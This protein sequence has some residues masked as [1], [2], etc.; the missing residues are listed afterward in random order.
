MAKKRTVSSR[1]SLGAVVSSLLLFANQSAA[2]ADPSAPPST[3][4]NLNLSSTKASISAA[5]VVGT[6]KSVTI[7][8]GGRQ[9]SVTGS[10]LLTPAEM[11]AVHQVVNTGQQSLSIGPYGNAVSGTLQIGTPLANL[12]GMVVPR[13]V[14]VSSALAALNISGDLSNSG[15][16]HF[17]GGPQVTQAVLAANN[18]FNYG[19]ISS[20]IN[21]ALNATGKIV[22]SGSISTSTGDLSLGANSI[23]NNAGGLISAANNLNLL[24]GN[25]TNAGSLIAQTGN[26]NI[27]TS[28]P[29]DILI[30]NSGG[31]MQALLG[32]INVRDAS[33][34]T[35]TNN[36]T[37]NGGNLFSHELNLFSACGAVNTNLQKVTGT[38]NVHAKEAHI[39]AAT[40][41][42]KIGVM[43]L[44]GDPTFYNTQGSVTID[45]PMVFPGQALAIVAK[46]NIVSSAAG[47]LDTSSNSAN[48]GAITLVAG[49]KF[50]VA[51][52]NTSSS[53]TSGQN[54]GIGDSTNTI[55]IT[56]GSA[57]GGY[58][59]LTGG[60]GDGA[61]SNPITINSKS[62]ST[63]GGAQDG[64]NVTLV[65]YGGTGSN[66]GTINLPAPATT[67][68]IVSGGNGTGANGNV[69]IIAGSKKA[70]AIAINIGGINTLGGSG[71]G[72]DV[73]LSTSLPAI[74]GGSSVSILNGV[75]QAG[76]SFT[77]GAIQPTSVTLINDSTNSNNINANTIKITAGNNISWFGSGNLAPA[78]LTDPLIYGPFTI[79]F[80]PSGT[81]AYVTNF[82]SNNFPFGP[83]VPLLSTTVSVIN[84]KTNAITNLTVGN[85]PSGVAFNPAGTIAYVTNY[86]HPGSVAGIGTVSVI[87]ATTN[88]VTPTTITV[89]QGP[90]AVE[91]NATGTTAYVVNYVSNTV[92]VIDVA[93]SK[94]VKTINVGLKPDAIAINPA[95]TKAYVGNSLSGTISVIDLKTNTVTATIT[96]LN[97]PYNLSVTPDGKF[98]YAANSGQPGSGLGVDTISVINTANNKIVATIN[99]PNGTPSG[100]A[101][102]PSGTFVYSTDY[103]L[104][105][106][107]GTQFGVDGAS[108]VNVI[109]TATNSIVHTFDLSGPPYNDSFINSVSFNPSG[110]IAYV[111]N[112]NNSDP[113]PPAVPQST[114]SVINIAPPVLNAQ[115]VTLSAG[116]KGGGSITAF[117][118]TPALTANAAGNV[119]VYNTGKVALVAN[120]TLHNSAAGTF[121][122]ITSPDLAGDG[123]IAINDK[124]TAS[125]K[126]GTIILQSSDATGLGGI[127]QNNSGLLAATTVN[128]SDPLRDI[129]SGVQAILTKAS[130]LQ[131]NTI[132]DV[133]INNTGTSTVSGASSGG[134]FSLTSSGA[135]KINNAIKATTQLTLNPTIASGTVITQQPTASITTP[136][137]KISLLNAA[138]ANLTGTQNS[139]DALIGTGSGKSSI[140]VNTLGNLQLE[141]FGNSQIATVTAGG[142]ITPGAVPVT[143][144][145]LTAT[146]NAVL[147]GAQQI[148]SST[149]SKISLTATGP[150]GISQS[151]GGNI[152][153]Q[154]VSLSASKDLATIEQSST[155]ALDV[156]TPLLSV[157]TG[158]GGTALINNLGT[159]PVTITNSSANSGTISLTSAGSIIAKGTVATGILVLNSAAGSITGNTETQFL[160]ANTV[161]NNDINLTNKGSL[162]LAN[163]GNGSQT[164]AAGGNF[165]LK[166]D[167]TLTTFLTNTAGGSLSFTAT[168][169]LLQSCT[170][171]ANNGNVV[172]NAN[173]QATGSIILQNQTTISA[174]SVD[175]SNLKLGNVI[176]S[177][178]SAN[179]A[180]TNTTTPANITPA[181]SAGG[182]IFYGK[183]SITSL[184]ANNPATPPGNNTLTATARNIIFSTGSAPA[185]AIQLSGQ[186]S[187]TASGY[188]Q[189]QELES[190]AEIIVDTGDWLEGSQ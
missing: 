67:Q 142:A 19:I 31:T 185:S 43:D 3:G 66:A 153:A 119:S 149:T 118:Q 70:A 145:T 154:S 155:T 74:T 57:E 186:D 109:N 100:I 12:S 37:I 88:T 163:P 141:T 20:A 157:N 116:S 29:T 87:D 131:A 133:F 190:D 1:A 89:G 49:A 150:A 164:C 84:T 152:T 114:I 174:K 93:S 115:S 103:T 72:G 98:L 127:I 92:S 17:T 170:L 151:A 38:I 75:V 53:T 179:P 36:V 188:E 68:A 77:A 117:T 135:I 10:T 76:G 50:T 83:P 189:E 120:G 124:V 32:N 52:L 167:G 28:S 181:V 162:V 138:K 182:N 41:N 69:S 177:V 158:T 27:N 56:G 30:N 104:P 9:T 35:W 178:G 82:G 54:A 80:N 11:A 101:V 102:N 143:V 165:T 7:S 99:D 113:G 184:N 132:G 34:N 137:L 94:V 2:F 161:G 5:S 134:L 63:T 79:D 123:R 166:V 112:Y 110:T 62:T 129:G 96:G 125:G 40:E 14:Q 22:N 60:T 61:G 55:K 64:G 108:T 23:T 25:I 86:N 121:Q 175:P 187:I 59:D 51:P 107:T 8:V 47:S 15:K 160:I 130:N 65:A 81:F 16:I 140:S 44:T 172:L 144:G 126:T 147:L 85:M 171:T 106:K 48:G 46:T 168:N 111:A 105:G 148:G 18:I 180:K 136:S 176:I 146:G 91:F 42:L 78:D 173:N 156:T 33:F 26:L 73:N 39:T 21:L 183:N 45:S 71:S 139:I 122:L 4:P 97:E 90:A 159:S 95:G 24:S 6:N 13:N 128:L 58:I 169:I